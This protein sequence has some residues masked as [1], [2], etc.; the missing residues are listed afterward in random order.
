MCQGSE[1]NLWSARWFTLPV[2]PACLRREAGSDDLPP[3]IQAHP[4]KQP[5]EPG[6][7]I[8]HQEHRAGDVQRLP[9]ASP[10]P[11]QDPEQ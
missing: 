2:P 10:E 11:E 5:V 6:D 3:V 9:V 7:V 4:D 1:S 8:G